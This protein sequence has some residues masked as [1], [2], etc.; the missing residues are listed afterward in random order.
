MPE[1]APHRPGPA[2]A[3]LAPLGAD[4]AEACALLTDRLRSAGLPVGPH[5]AA[6]L[7]RAVL[8]LEPATRDELYWCARVTHVSS[9]EQIATFDA[10]FSALFGG[11]AAGTEPRGQA[12]STPQPGA[13]PRAEPAGSAPL[14]PEPA[15][16]RAL[17]G[18]GAGEGGERTSYLRALASAEERLANV[19]FAELSAEELAALAPFLR[20]LT[21]SVPTRLSRRR[22]RSPLGDRV[23][24]RATLRRASRSAGDPWT[25]VRRRRRRRPR[26]LVA[27]LDI[28]GSME[29]YARAYLQALWGVT[30]AGRA[31]TFVFSTRLTRLTR[32]MREAAPSSSLSKA[33]R[34]APDWSGGTRIGESLKEL[35]DSHGRPGLARGAVVL[36]VS[37]G[38][39]RGDPALLR[40]Q[41]E[42]LSRLAH[43]IV[44]VN[45]R[46]ADPAFEPLAGGMAAALP[47]LDALVSGHSASSLET[48]LEALA[49]R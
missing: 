40:R 47:Y 46:A 37:D 22:R 44:W 9:E 48:V 42:A 38:W 31:E 34:L 5:S 19:D 26:R 8:V 39:E 45:P 32:V 11:L 17:A 10:V 7:A 35:V 12:G 25:I 43:R 33:G 16:L 20:K 30:K 6:S 4:L 23:D 1:P 3:E 27:V 49:Q 14:S 13:P 15:G 21:V 29:P 36:I 41:I 24:L 28:S 2:V 18:E